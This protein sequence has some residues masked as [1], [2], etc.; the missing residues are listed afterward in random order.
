M[1]QVAA[2]TKSNVNVNVSQHTEEAW[3]KHKPKNMLNLY[4]IDF[5]ITT[6]G[7]VNN[8]PFGNFISFQSELSRL[9]KMVEFLAL[10]KIILNK[11]ILIIFLFTS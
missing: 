9:C 1:N 2:P 7:T 6:Q 10:S 11:I 5:K 8:I 3:K 4:L